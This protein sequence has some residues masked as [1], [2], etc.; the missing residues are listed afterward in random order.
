MF[1]LFI[2]VR[3]VANPL[4]N[5]FQKLLTRNGADPLFVVCVTHALLSVACFWIV[6]QA[7]PPYGAEFWWNMAMGSLLGVAGNALLV[8]AMK[9]SDLSV[10][11]PINAYKSVVSLLPAAVMLGEWPTLP[12][13]AGIALVVAGSYGLVDSAGAVDANRWT[14]P[15]RDR[16]VQCRFAALILA[17]IETVFLKRALLVSSPL[18]TLVV[19]AVFGMA[20]ALAAVLVRL[21]RAEFRRQTVLARTN[22]AT[23]LWLL[24]TTASMQLATIVV[25]ADLHVGYALALFQVSAMVSVLLG[26]QVFR[27]AHFLKR[28]AGS[29]VMV[30]GAILIV[31]YR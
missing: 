8:Q 13:L 20:V 15:W 11:G 23:Y 30:A 26:R 17:A 29:T 6:P 21:D 16:G 22:L 27:E 10:L 4:S 7:P 24:L 12:A 18:T 25:I 19:W 28:L 3:I 31:V 14:A 1:W 5:V 2:A 9:L